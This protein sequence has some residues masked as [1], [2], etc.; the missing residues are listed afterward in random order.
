MHC[1][2]QITKSNKTFKTK[3]LRDKR[4]F[5]S[6]TPEEFRINIRIVLLKSLASHHLLLKENLGKFIQRK[7]LFHINILTLDINNYKVNTWFIKWES[8]I[9][10]GKNNRQ[11]KNLFAFFLEWKRK[12]RQFKFKAY[13]K[14]PKK[15]FLLFISLRN[16][17]LKVWKSVAC[18]IPTLEIE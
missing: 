12:S 1:F 4:W 6:H 17:D 15:L 5:L 18:R 7:H 14:L 2:T 16:Q 8:S 10:L 11:L 13:S 9:F 3:H